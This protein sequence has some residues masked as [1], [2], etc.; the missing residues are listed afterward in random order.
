MDWV[1]KNRL[2]LRFKTRLNQ[3]LD[4]FQALEDF[5]WQSSDMLD[6]LDDMRED[7]NHNDFADEVSALQ[8]LFSAS[9]ILQQNARLV[10]LASSP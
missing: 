7:L 2:K 10:R 4:Y 6:R 8:N 3:G 9:P 1:L 5:M